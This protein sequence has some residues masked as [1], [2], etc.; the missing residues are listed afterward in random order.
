MRINYLKT[1]YSQEEASEVYSKIY[2]PQGKSGHNMIPPSVLEYKVKNLLKDRNFI[3]S[4]KLSKITEQNV[5]VEL[6]LYSRQSFSTVV[7]DI[8]NKDV[9]EKFLEDARNMVYKDFFQNKKSILK[10]NQNI[11]KTVENLQNFQNNSD[12]GL[13]KPPKAL[14]TNENFKFDFEELISGKKEFAYF[15]KI[16][17]I[18]PM[19]PNQNGLFVTHGISTDKAE[20][21]VKHKTT[22]GE[23]F[24]AGQVCDNFA[25]A[26]DKYIYNVVLNYTQLGQDEPKIVLAKL[27]ININKQETLKYIASV[28]YWLIKYIMVVL[29]T[30]AF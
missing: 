4:I 16:A 30:Y 15:Y 17:S 12:I 5:L 7:D 6:I 11:D 22:K 24:I 28:L 25:Y 29:A 2:F 23:S 19:I 27:V 10:V 13:L 26:P 3:D 1:V 21:T 8:R 9:K 14:K 20:N 18:E